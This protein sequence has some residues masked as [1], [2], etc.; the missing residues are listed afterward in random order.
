MDR[1]FLHV[2]AIPAIRLTER[3]ILIDLFFW[4]GMRYS[5][6]LLRNEIKLWKSILI[7][8]NVWKSDRLDEINKDSHD[9]DKRY[10]KNGFKI[11]FV[12]IILDNADQSRIIIKDHV[13][14]DG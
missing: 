6:L 4:R 11:G 3:V 5:A 14:E 13:I 8:D 9:Q 7:E 2:P 12:T 10:S 1:F